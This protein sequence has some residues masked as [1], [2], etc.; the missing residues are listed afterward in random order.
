[1]SDGEVTAAARIVAIGVD[2]G[3]AKA[4]AGTRLERWDDI[5]PFSESYPRARKVILSRIDPLLREL[6]RETCKGR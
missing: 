2:I 4:L 6:E 5:P 1:L 3:E